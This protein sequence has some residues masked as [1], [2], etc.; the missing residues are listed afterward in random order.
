MVRCASCGCVIDFRA[1]VARVEEATGESTAEGT[2]GPA[3]LRALNE[4]RIALLQIGESVL[5]AATYAEM[6]P[7]RVAEEFK[8]EWVRRAGRTR[9]LELALARLC[10]HAAELG[11]SSSGLH[12]A[13]AEA[14][15]LL[16]AGERSVC[17]GALK[18]LRRARD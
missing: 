18:L 7:A 14:Y 5:P 13:V 9:R 1:V 6:T 16:A 3:A 8:R 4:S 2:A 12:P 10:R 11:P 17:D 15:E